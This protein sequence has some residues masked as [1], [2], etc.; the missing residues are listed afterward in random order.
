MGGCIGAM[1][2]EVNYYRS[3]FLG[4]NLIIFCRI[5]QIKGLFCKS[6]VGFG[7]IYYVVIQDIIWI[8]YHPVKIT[9]LYSVGDRRFWDPI[10]AVLA[11]VYLRSLDEGARVSFDIEQGQNSPSAMNVTV[12]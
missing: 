9:E 3:Y 1:F 10:T 4:G 5:I 2:V 11:M 8:S 7:K 6:H 12:V